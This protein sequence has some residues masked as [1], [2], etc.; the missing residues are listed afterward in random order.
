MTGGVASLTE[1]RSTLAATLA[2][3]SSGDPPV[4][5]FGADAFAPPAILIR[6]GD[7]WLDQDGGGMCRY[8]ARLEAWAVTG[9]AE[10]EAATPELE[11]MLS[12]LL[13]RLAADPYP[14]RVSVGVPGDLVIAGLTY[15]G[16]RA[17]VTAPT[18]PNPEV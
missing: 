6:W 8:N 11:Q 9:R 15:F 7:P 1:L 18:I 2:P 17:T 5:P 13:R 4:I 16:C 3:A 14:W 12:D 10:P